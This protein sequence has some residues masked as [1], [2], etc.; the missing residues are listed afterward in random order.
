MENWKLQIFVFGLES[1]VK[2]VFLE[3]GRAV[4]RG[5]TAY[6]ISP[7]VAVECTII[8]VVDGD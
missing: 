5:L 1:R 4:S 8:V 6:R 3:I 2:G 7:S